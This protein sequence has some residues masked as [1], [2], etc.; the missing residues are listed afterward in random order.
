MIDLLYDTNPQIRQVTDACL[1]IISQIDGEWETR[2]KRQKFAWHNSE[3]IKMIT[4]MSIHGDNEIVIMVLMMTIQI[5]V[6]LAL[7]SA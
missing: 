7:K 6:C 4:T 5:P 2:L 1:E 3:W